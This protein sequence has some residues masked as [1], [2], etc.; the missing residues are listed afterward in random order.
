MSPKRC[1]Q[2]P[3]L[4]VACLAAAALIFTST[5][6]AQQPQDDSMLREQRWR[7]GSFGV[8]LRPPVD[9]KLQESGQDGLLQ[10]NGFNRYTIKFQ[11]SDSKRPLSIDEMTNELLSRV[12]FLSPSATVL[13]KHN[14]QAQPGGRPGALLYMRIPD[15]KAGPWILGQALMQIDPTHFAYLRLETDD[16]FFDAA[17]P[18]FEAVFESLRLE[19]V[20]Q[21]NKQRDAL[22][23]RGQA[24]IETITTEKVLKT[25]DHVGLT[26]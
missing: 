20:E 6:A 26:D 22:V 21:L 17:R 14:R 16:R 19:S 3:L 10:I 15:E 5:I 8:S 18:L 9:A 11:I 1:H 12:A 2:V 23:N 25:D 7:E 24:W 4:V 13:E